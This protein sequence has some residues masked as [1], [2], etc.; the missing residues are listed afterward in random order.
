MDKQK[1]IEEI[2]NVICSE[3]YGEYCKCCNLK[4][5]CTECERV[6]TALYNAGYRKISEGEVVLT[7]G[8]YSDM[9]SAEV[10]TIERDIAEYWANE[11]AESVAKEL[12]KDGYRKLD[13]HAILVL[14]KAKGLEEKV[15]KETAEK[16]AE[17]LKE[18]AYQSTDWSHGEHP[19]V[20]EVDYID[21][22]CE[23]LTMTDIQMR[24]ENIC[25][26]EKDTVKEIAGW[27]DGY[28]LGFKEGVEAVKVQLKEKIADFDELRCI[29]VFNL[30][31]KI[32]KE[33]TE[34]DNG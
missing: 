3:T 29:K 24:V 7:E 32:C 28:K 27:L 6:A 8:E 31:D 13:D 15:R 30:L 18:M 33:I 25:R 22:I 21:E 12:H 14:R 23:E 9:L 26:G 4:G 17:R 34:G 20:V 11:D 1:Q 10:E 16:Y 19:M 5:Y 2:E